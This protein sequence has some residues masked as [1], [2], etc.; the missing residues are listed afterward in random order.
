MKVL[1]DLKTLNFNMQKYIFILLILLSKQFVFSQLTDSINYDFNSE[2]NIRTSQNINEFLNDDFYLYDNEPAQ[3]T[4][5]IWQRLVAYILKIISKLFSFINIGG[6]TATYFFYILALLFFLFALSKI[7]GFSYQSLFLNS[8][9]T[10]AVG[11]NE[12]DEDIH[13]I[14]FNSIINKA[15]QEE[16]FRLAIRYLYIRHLK[17]LTDNELINW[18]IAKTNKDYEK[19]MMKTVFFEKHKQLSIIYE[20]IWYGEFFIDK[21]R[22]EKYK[23]EFNDFFKKDVSN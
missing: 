20:H 4:L 11:L 12:F 19:E 13:S 2:I 17:Y 18:Q 9:K 8:K 14:N 10:Q 1:T 16:D 6:K 3:E 23:T 5:T 22:Y 7:F 21:L 15:E